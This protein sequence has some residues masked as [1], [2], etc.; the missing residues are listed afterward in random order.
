MKVPVRLK[1]CDGAGFFRRTLFPVLPG[2]RVELGL[3]S[4][5][6]QFLSL[7]VQ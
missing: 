3:I 2:C 6:L 5:R 7:G 4:L 1:M